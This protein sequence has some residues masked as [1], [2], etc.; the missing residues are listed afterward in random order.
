MGVR[1]PP[2]QA[3]LDDYRDDVYRFLVTLVGPDEADDCFQEAF[4]SALRAYPRLRDGS[5][6]KGWVMTIAYR[7]GIDALRGR[8]RRPDP[9]ADVPERPHD[10]PEVRDPAVWATVRDLP[11]KQRTALALRV[12]GDLP[13]RQV[14]RIM[15]STE[16][17]ARRNAHDALARLREVWPR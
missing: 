1:L 8:A 5:N 6:L 12:V 7:K 2:F 9:V 13:Y 4:L 3:V 15:G 16:E 17:A 11:P 14:A 10:P